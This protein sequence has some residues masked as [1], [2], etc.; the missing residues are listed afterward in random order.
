VKARVGIDLAD[1]LNDLVEGQAQAALWFATSERGVRHA[2]T[3]R[4]VRE[5]DALGRQ[6][7]VMFILE[8]PSLE[9]TTRSRKVGPALELL[10][11]RLDDS[12]VIPL[13]A[14][15]RVSRKAA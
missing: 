12:K 7:G 9:L 10:A 13:R 2:C 3:G 8:V 4:L 5:V 14:R 6:T 15:A 1:L 11:A